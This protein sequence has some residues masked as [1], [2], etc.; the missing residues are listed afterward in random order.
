ME[1][2][3][4]AAEAAAVLSKNSGKMIS[5]GYLKVLAKYGKLHPVKIGERM[6]LYPKAEVDSYIVEGRGG[7]TRDKRRLNEDLTTDI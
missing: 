1:G 5:P 2:F 4:T 3:Y 7:K 6:N